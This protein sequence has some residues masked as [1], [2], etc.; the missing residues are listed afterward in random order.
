M[1]FLIA[2]IPIKMVI[3]NIQ[4]L[5]SFFWVIFNLEFL[6]ATMD[7]SLFMKSEKLR[8]AFQLFD[9]DGN[10]KISPEE[11]KEVLGSKIIFDE[12]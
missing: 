1:R 7:K 3:L 11:L 9:K 6:A 2:W 12:C 8:S 5:V 4:V 10:G